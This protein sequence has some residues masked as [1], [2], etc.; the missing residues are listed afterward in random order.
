MERAWATA[1]VWHVTCGI[2]S[3]SPHKNKLPLAFHAQCVWTQRIL[4]LFS[5][6]LIFRFRSILVPKLNTCIA[7]T[8]SISILQCAAYCLLLSHAEVLGSRFRLRT[9][10]SGRRRLAIESSARDWGRRIEFSIFEIMIDQARLKDWWSLVELLGAI[11]LNLKWMWPSVHLI[12][13]HVLQGSFGLWPS[14]P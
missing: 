7:V 5:I 14:T 2:S 8:P 9:L 3:M 10:L 13:D 11:V 4:N 6:N 1:A 12:P